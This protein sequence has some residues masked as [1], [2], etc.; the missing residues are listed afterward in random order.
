LVSEKPTV[1]IFIFLIILRLFFI[2]EFSFTFSH[3]KHQIKND[4]IKLW[5]ILPISALI[6]TLGF[7]LGQYIALLFYKLLGIDP[8][9]QLVI[10]FIIGFIL[11]SLIFFFWIKKQGILTEDEMNQMLENRSIEWLKS[12][13]IIL[14][15][16]IREIG[17]ELDLFCG[18]EGEKDD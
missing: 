1:F 6:T 5:Y 11:V 16:R 3:K 7:V 17:D 2:C 4:V 13:C 9:I 15:K 8:F 14:G 10:K 12:I 18:E